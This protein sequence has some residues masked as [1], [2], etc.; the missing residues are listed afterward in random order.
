MGILALRDTLLTTF[1]ADVP[2]R[3]ER[4]AEAIDSMDARRIEFEAHGLKGMCATVGAVT[5]GRVFSMMEQL[6][7]EERVKDVAV[8]L[9][10]ARTAVQRTEQYIAR[11]EKILSRAA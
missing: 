5:C 11:L 2:P 10:K 9:P 7:G 6:A 3:I 8:L 4:L 1:L